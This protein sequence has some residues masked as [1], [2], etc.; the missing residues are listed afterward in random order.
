MSI[1]SK[2]TAF[3]GPAKNEQ[4]MPRLRVSLRTCSRLFPGLNLHQL[5]LD[6]WLDN[7]LICDASL[8]LANPQFA[9]VALAFD[10]LRNFSC[11]FLS[12]CPISVAVS[13]LL[14]RPGWCR[15]DPQTLAARQDLQRLVEE[16]GDRRLTA[17]R[18]PLHFPARLRAADLVFT[19]QIGLSS[20]SER[21][22]TTWLR[23]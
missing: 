3:S 23:M 12:V 7:F 21:S 14:F 16:T 20:L 9:A 1:V 10:V 2:G 22:L 4:G 11:C 8:S 13:G 17:N 15:G 19:H 5:R 6:G 18:L